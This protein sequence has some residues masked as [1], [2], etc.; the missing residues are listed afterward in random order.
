LRVPGRRQRREI[1]WQ[2]P[3]HHN[4]A[5]ARTLPLPGFP[6]RALSPAVLCKLT[7][8]RNRPRGGVFV[9]EG[10]RQWPTWQ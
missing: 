9:S 5:R 6:R 10:K 7:P 4:A 8:P 2:G 1:A 3:C